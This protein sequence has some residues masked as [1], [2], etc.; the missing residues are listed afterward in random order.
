MQHIIK[1]QVFDLTVSHRLDVFPLQQKISSAYW[2]RI[3]PVLE[4]SFDEVSTENE[5]ITLERMEIDL[6]ILE[7]HEILGESA[8][9]DLEQTIIRQVREAII[10]KLYSSE[11]HFSAVKKEIAYLDQWL[12]YMKKG[13]LPW[14]TLS[15]SRDWKTKVLEALCVDH[16]SVFKVKETIASDIVCVKRIVNQHDE[17]FLLNLLEI[18]TAESQK[19]LLSFFTDL[20]KFATGS[21]NKQSGFRKS[22]WS[23]VLQGTAAQP[24]RWTPHALAIMILKKVIKKDLLVSSDSFRNIF[25]SLSS[26][27]DDRIIQF[28]A[29]GSS[30]KETFTGQKEEV[31]KKIP[32]KTI[33]QE[34]INRVLPFTEIVHQDTVNAVSNSTET[35]LK[36]DDIFLDN[37][38]AVLLHP[39][40]SML[41]S[42]AGLTENSTFIDKEAQQK[43]IYLVHYLATGNTSA[44]EH[45]LILAKVLCE[46]PL[47]EPLSTGISITATEMEEGDHLLEEV[48]SKWQVLKN[49]SITA[50]RES[51][52]QRKGK[53]SWKNDNLN[54]HIEPGPIDMLLDHLPWTVNIIKLPWMKNFIH[55]DWR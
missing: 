22:L 18:I 16:I 5:T 34:I 26:L 8:S 39:F 6:G 24:K 33:S 31:I 42:C 7:E 4:R 11:E 52:L 25:P 51:F 29:T 14:N 20:E 35:L 9:S 12:F 50:L 36:E 21:E 41:F 37:A 46:F 23:L 2:K 15:P 32:L 13:Y 40:L 17:T 19:D 44:E 49:A 55:V 53:L 3:L 27:P 45:E 38:G 43:A 1:K 28:V 30:L 10:K 48:I 54:L 47:Q